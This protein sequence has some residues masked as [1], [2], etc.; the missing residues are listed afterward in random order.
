MSVSFLSFLI[1]PKIDRFR[2]VTEVFA[3][4]I[5]G[6][7]KGPKRSIPFFQI[8]ASRF[9]CEFLSGT[10]LCDFSTDKFSTAG[11]GDVI[12]GKN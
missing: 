3:Y 9:I 2:T 5:N 7:T 1:P 12:S 10:L 6:A 4:F 11:R 8:S